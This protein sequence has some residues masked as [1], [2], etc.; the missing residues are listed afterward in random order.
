MAERLTAIDSLFFNLESETTPQTISAICVLD[1]TPDL[2]LLTERLEQL[3]PRFPRLARTVRRTGRP[4]WVEAVPFRIA[5]HIQLVALPPLSDRDTLFREASALITTPLDVTRPLWRVTVLTNEEF[6]QGG[7]CRPPVVGA[8]FSLH[9]SVADGLRGLDLLA[10]L[11]RPAAFATQGMAGK[12][13][14]GQGTSAVRPSASGLWMRMQRGMRTAR[15]ALAAFAVRPGRSPLN[16]PTSRERLLLTVDLSRSDLRIVMR[17]FRTSLHTVLL[18]VTSGAVRRF[19][20]V[21]NAPLDDLIVG[22]AVSGTVRRRTVDLGNHVALAWVPLP[23]S[24]AAPT[25][26]LRRIDA[27]LSRVDVGGTQGA[28]G[29]LATVTERF[30][31]WLRSAVLKLVTRNTSF[32]CAI[33]PGPS[34][35]RYLAGARVEAIYAVPAHVHGQGVSFTFVTSSGRV[36]VSILCDL[37]IVAAPALLNQHFLESMAELVALV[38]ERQRHETGVP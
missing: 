7:G 31:S 13:A 25:E 27:F 34:G 17:G 5:E 29:L 12:R 35:E 30:P 38:N 4:R 37:K 15:V 11:A 14:R 9:H 20:E 32:I 16:G 18:A 23:L 22:M 2:A 26:R 21:H 8:V 28:A 3:V 6:G 19:H 24:A 33:L 10:E 1:R 36:H